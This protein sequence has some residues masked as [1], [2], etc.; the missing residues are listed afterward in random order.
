MSSGAWRGVV[1]DLRRTAT[2]KGRSTLGCYS[3]EGLRLH[4]RALRAG[5]PVERVVVGETERRE[6]N[7]RLS[8]LLEDL[9]NSGCRIFTVPDEIVL[10]LTD[11][12]AAGGLVGLVRFPGPLDLPDVV[13]RAQRPVVLLVAVD[14]E[15]PGNVGALTRTAL[16][17]FAS[18][19]V[20]VGISDPYHPRAV[21]TSM[22]SVFKLPVVVRPR[23]APVVEE[24]RDLG[25]ATV[26]AV[27]SGAIDLARAD[28]KGERLALLMGSEA[29]GMDPEALSILDQRV[30]I[31][32]ASGID[33]FSVNAAAAILLHE[34]Y[35][36][37][38]AGG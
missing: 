16:A 33:S 35:R 30:R 23:L 27:P 11:G 3:I 9:E 20:A 28:L 36:R 17:G 15:D 21:R 7:H 34:I 1:A 18:A 37:S 2:P 31:P 32:M 24:L 29:F 10:D 38:G 14:V 12:R 13:R 25:F 22:G 8:R 26:G 4:E 5:A 19:F 6:G